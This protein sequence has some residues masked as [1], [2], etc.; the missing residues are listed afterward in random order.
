MKIQ[1]VAVILMVMLL[2][3]NVVMAANPI[4]SNIYPMNNETNVELDSGKVYLR[5]NIKDDDGDLAYVLF[6]TNKSGTWQKITEVYVAG[7]NWTT[8]TAITMSGLSYSKTYWWRIKAKDDADHWT[9]SSAYKFKTEAEPSSGEIQ[10]IPSQPRAGKNIVFLVDEDEASGYLLC[11]ETTN[12]YLIEINNGIGIVE[13]GMEYGDAL[14]KIIGYGTKTFTIAAPYEGDLIIDIPSVADLNEDVALSVYAG[15]EMVS[16]TVTIT[17]P[18]GLESERKTSENSP[19]ELSFDESGNWTLSTEL[20]DTETTETI[21]INPEPLE[22]DLPREDDM[23]VGKEMQLRINNP[24]TVVF[25]KDETSWTYITDDDGDVY[26]IPPFPG[27]YKITAKT[28]GQ[29]GTKYFNVKADAIITIKNEAGLQVNSVS[30]GDVLLV[31]V[32]DSTGA[33]IDSSSV[34]VYADGIIIRSLELFSGSTLWAVSQGATEYRFEFYPENDV[35]YLPATISLVGQGGLAVD[36]LYLYIGFAIFIII[37]AIYIANTRG[38]ISL[39]KFFPEKDEEE[40]L[41]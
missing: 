19:L 30:Q 2:S 38:W 8:D 17:S 39:R 20:Y 24:A 36:A 15:G 40:D 41:L 13:L 18:A 31:Q 5:A 11:E 28:L 21:Y 7:Q 35:L 33:S 9:N 3:V 23:I 25:E 32:T 22:I 27:R 1:Y 34:D 37:V 14:V 16:A 6:E 29:S 26:F 12:V 10:I 4:V